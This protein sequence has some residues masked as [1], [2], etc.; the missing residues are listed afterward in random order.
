M[1]IVVEGSGNWALQYFRALK[2]LARPGDGIFFTYDSTFGLDE[3][4]EKLPAPLF[5]RYLDATLRN[6]QEIE[7][8][9]FACIDTKDTLFRLRNQR[10]VCRDVLPRSVDAVFVV[11]PDRTH[12][13]VATEWLG[14]ARR[15]FVEK[16][17]DVSTARV[18]QFCNAM[19]RFPSTETFAVDHYFVRCNQA[20]V[21]AEYFLRSLLPLNRTGGLGDD[22]TSFEFRM[23]EPPEPNNASIGARALSMQSGMVMDMGSHAL[24]VLLP[25]ID[26]SKPIIAKPIWAGVSRGL[27]DVMYGGAETFSI[28]DVECQTRST[29]S[30]PSS[31]L[32]RGRFAVG[33][34]IGDRPEKYLEVSGPRG[35]IRFDLVNYMVHEIRQGRETYL[36]PLQQDWARL[37]VH[38]VLDDRVPAAV[39]MFTPAGALNVVRFLETWRNA[40]RLT[41]TRR[42]LE[43]HD[44][45]APLSSLDNPR[46][47]VL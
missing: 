1:R 40:C 30:K 21:A 44:R 6:V 33:K 11:T 37:F 17:F 38:E 35:T 43:L 31:S 14:R 16:P 25:F 28:A 26:L 22:F 15:I 13:D 45:G 46:Y 47:R 2:A 39:E 3:N 5:A 12:C 20:A 36:A 34:D 8:A 23:T 4:A 9:G 29:A 7:A 24:P 42:A 32:I 27:R 18:Q 10:N 41:G 19:A